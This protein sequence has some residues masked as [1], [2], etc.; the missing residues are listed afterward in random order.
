MKKRLRYT[1]AALAI[2][3]TALSST[4][5]FAYDDG[6]DHESTPE[7]AP[8]G[9]TVILP[10][11]GDI[12]PFRGDI[13][14][15]AGDISPFRGDIDPFYGDISPFWGDIS[16]FWGDI[17]PFAGDIDPF[18]GDIS[19]F[20]GDISPFTGDID[21]FAGDIS[22][23]TGDISPFWGDI[24]PFWGD[25]GPF[26][27]DL[28]AYW[29]DIDPFTEASAGDYEHL[30]A[31]LNEMFRR[32]EE[33][34]G[35]AVADQ[36]GRDF[37]AGFLSGLLDAYGIDP[38]DVA[39][40]EGM[41]A[42]DRSRF[43]LDFYDGLMNFSGIDRVDHWMA[44]TN[45]SPSLAYSVGMGGGVT[46]GLL[47]FTVQGDEGMN[48]R[49]YRGDDTYSINHG[50][51][52]ASLINAPIDG[53]GV[54]GM[55]QEATILLHNPFDET[56]STN[57]EDVTQGIRELTLQGAS[58]VNM[59]LGVPDWTFHYGWA[60]VFSNTMVSKKGD[61]TLFVVAAG[62]DGFTQ[63]ADVDWTEVGTVANLLIVGSVNPAG[64]ISSFSNRPGDACFTV[65]SRCGEGMRLMDRF[66][67]APGELL[68]VSDGNGGTTRMSGTSFAAPLVT[69]TA[70]LVQGRWGWLTAPQ[71]AD[72]ILWSAQDLGAEGVD[73]VYGWGLLDTRASLSPFSTSDLFMVDR[74]GKRRNVRDLGVNPGRLRFHS[75][76]DAVV[77]MF[78]EFQ[79][80][81]RDFL[82]SLDELMNDDSLSEEQ[83]AAIMEIYL[84]ERAENDRNGDSRSFTDVNETTRLVSA[85]GDLQVT[86]FASRLDPR[87]QQSHDDLPFQA[88]VE[89]ADRT[90]GRSLRFGAGEGAMAL[91]QQSGFGLF[92][93]HRPETGGV[94]PVLGFASGGAY[95]MT[96]FRVD[97]PTRVSF[98][99]TSTSDQQ[100]FTN[101]FTGEQRALYDGMSAY[102]A[103]AFVT[104]V[105]HE[106][107]ERVTLNASYTYLNEATGF[108]GA[109]GSG[110]LAFEGG[111]STDSVTVGAE[112]F[113]PLNIQ[114]S[115]SATFA[116]TRATAFDGD[117]LEMPE[118]TLSTAFQLTARRDGVFS[119]ADAVRISVIQPLHVENGSLDFTAGRVIDR[120]TGEIGIET[121]TWQLG[122]ERAIFTEVLYA[123]PVFGGAGDLA[124][125][126]RFEVAGGTIRDETGGLASGARF[127]FEF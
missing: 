113:L 64:G 57:W 92:S 101:P 79:D 8:A 47:D 127:R 32:A 68:L 50:A 5:A 115:S 109:Q 51:A 65:N 4:S 121:D 112:A 18:A 126:G 89:I 106:V 42:A 97:A 15:F 22:P 36:T 62:N 122:S 80:T 72:V 28:N 19:P 25:I 120:S 84:A 76:S 55:A 56:L 69:G 16:P 45:W 21:P 107:G 61:E 74:N 102:Q 87:E 99:I 105:R 46:V 91:T 125:F 100:L 93:D 88:G 103:T 54:M 108:L 35:A 77:T 70:A 49:T 44:S 78:E 53:R 37:N 40:L 23:F 3:M 83:R 14:P 43:F 117:F 24:Q 26:W 71:V 124:V 31:Q 39:S 90:S 66:L 1:T 94:N 20:W 110:P 98:G 13:D 75:T 60:D 67:V 6:H 58:V 123:T 38:N 2:A 29:G 10:H 81:H 27:G 41:D 17:D 59:S 85:S 33:V 73:D 34:F 116:R 86:A 111:T 95:M 63:T 114:L 96:S 104:D 7:T 9:D 12:D 118:D 48:I 11:R 119:G 30:S 82:I 52:V